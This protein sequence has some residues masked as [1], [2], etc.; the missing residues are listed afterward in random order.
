MAKT[1]PLWLFFVAMRD[2]CGQMPMLYVGA[3]C[4][5]QLIRYSVYFCRLPDLKPNGLTGVFAQTAPSGPLY[6]DGAFSRLP[7]RCY[8]SQD[9]IESGCAN[10]CLLSAYLVC[11]VFRGV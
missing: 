10:V 1:F 2:A 4:F 3:A 9:P 6:A 11:T 8:R 5:I 7:Q